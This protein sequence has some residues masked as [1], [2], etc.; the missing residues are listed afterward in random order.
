[1]NFLFIVTIK[2]SKGPLFI[3][4][5]FLKYLHCNTVKNDTPIPSGILHCHGRHDFIL[6]FILLSVVIAVE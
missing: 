5:L 3:S 6:L 1:M 2:P 4:S